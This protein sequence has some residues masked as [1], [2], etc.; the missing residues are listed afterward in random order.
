MVCFQIYFIRF[1]WKASFFPHQNSLYWL[2]EPIW[3]N[4]KRCRKKNKS[5]AKKRM[6]NNEWWRFWNMK[7]IDFEKSQ[8]EVNVVYSTKT[9]HIN[10]IWV[11]MNWLCKFRLS[12]MPPLNQFHTSSFDVVPF[13]MSVQ[14]NKMKRSLKVP[15]SFILK[16]ETYL[17]SMPPQARYHV[18]NPEWLNKVLEN[19]IKSNR[20][21]N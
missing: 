4:L 21:W 9:F 19:K 15:P 13:Y 7:S 8:S 6:M 18:C 1:R 10:F 17:K 5:K 12:V 16:T 11:E 20:I 3:I 14:P 2:E